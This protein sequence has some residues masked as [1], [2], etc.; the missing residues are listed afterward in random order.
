MRNLPPPP[1]PGIMM[2]PPGFM[3]GPPG[4][5]G[6]PPGPQEMAFGAGGGPFEGRGLPPGGFRR[7]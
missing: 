5:G 1:P 4:M 3:G 6:F 7:Q 2:P